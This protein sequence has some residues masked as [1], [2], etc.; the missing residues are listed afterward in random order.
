V[1]A[2]FGSNYV[3]VFITILCMLLILIHY[4]NNNNNN[5]NLFHRSTRVNIELVNRL[6]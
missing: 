2:W 6:Q 3:A 4:N 5:N 1:A